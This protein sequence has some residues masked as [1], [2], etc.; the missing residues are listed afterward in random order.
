MSELTVRPVDPS[1]ADDA[2]PP[3]GTAIVRPL[4][5]VRAVRARY[6]Q[7]FTDPAEAAASRSARAWAWALGEIALAPVTDRQTATPPR[8][9]EMEAEITE[10]ERRRVRGTREGRADAAATV[11][12][13]LL[14]KDDHAPVRCTNPG[15]L[16]GGFGD[17]VRS[18]EQI[19][20]LIG[21]AAPAQ[22][23][24]A[25]RSQ[26]TGTAPG[27]REATRREAEYLDGVLM[28]LAWVNRQSA[29][30]PASHAR[31][32]AASRTLKQE[33]LRAED[34][35]E[36]G[37]DQPSRSYGEGVLSTISWLLGDSTAPPYPFAESS[38]DR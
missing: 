10:A 21:L 5:H 7:R 9:V 12:C 20:D 11:L 3:E 36:D 33:R 31:V 32:G 26:D 29:E 16:V 19:A 27:G 15:E 35:I 28:T 34:A 13:W 6:L 37:A 2:A 4:R 23:A 25:V 14:G 1:Q 24:A 38:A 22:R 17:I 30:A 8:R 18:R